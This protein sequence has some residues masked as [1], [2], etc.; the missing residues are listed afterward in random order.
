M[1][2]NVVMKVVN[3]TKDFPGVRALDNINFDL[4]KGE[5]HGLVG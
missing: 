2:E 1:R 4:L 5:I 3:L